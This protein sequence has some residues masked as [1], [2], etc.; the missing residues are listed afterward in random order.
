MF[1]KGKR[2]ETER[3]KAEGQKVAAVRRNCTGERKSRKLSTKPE[4]RAWKQAMRNGD[5]PA[6]EEPLPGEN[7][8]KGKERAESQ[9][10]GTVPEVIERERKGTSQDRKRKHKVSTS[11]TAA[12]A[13]LGGAKG[14]EQEAEY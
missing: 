14:N 9:V 3:K 13:K 4:S 12:G 7:G 8:K 10:A 5:K 1:T 6:P 2:P 11:G